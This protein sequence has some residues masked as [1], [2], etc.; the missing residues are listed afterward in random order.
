[1]L[2]NSATILIL[3]MIFRV[4][5]NICTENCNDVSTFDETEPDYD[6]FVRNL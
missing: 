1:M 3:M 2:P 6:Q 4:S 5:R